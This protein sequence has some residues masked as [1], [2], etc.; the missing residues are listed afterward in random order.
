MAQQVFLDKEKLICSICFD[1]QKDPVTIPCGHSYCL[2]CIQNF[3]IGEEPKAPSCPQCRQNFTS[4]PVLVRNTILAE[5]VEDARKAE[6]QPTSSERS[7]TGPEH[8]DCDFCEGK[9]LKAAMSCLTCMVSYCEQHL[10]LHF[11]VAALKKH[12][13]VKATLKL[14]ENICIRHDEVIKIFC[15]TDQ[16]CICSL[17]SMDEHKGHDMVSAAAERAERQTKLGLDQQKVQQRILNLEEDLEVLQQAVEAI[18]LSAEKTIKESQNL[19]KGL[20]CLLEQ[21]CSEVEQKVTSYQRE[22]VRKVEELQEKMQHEITKLKKTEAELDQLSST[23]DHLH[24]LNNYSSLSDLSICTDLP[25]FEQA[26]HC[27]D[28]A[29]KAVSETREKLEETLRDQTTKILD[30]V[31]VFLP[32]DFRSREDFMKYYHQ[33]TLDPNTANRNLSLSEQNRTATWTKLEQNYSSHPDRFAKRSQVLSAEGLT[34]RCY[35]EVDWSGVVYIAVA[36]KDRSGTGTWDESA[37]GFNDKSWALKCSPT[38]Y[39][40]Y[41]K[42]SCVSIAAPRSSRVGVYLNHKAGTLSFY[43]ISDSMT[44]LHKVQTTFTQPLHAGF[45]ISKSG[46]M[47]RLLK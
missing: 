5:L 6:L 15:R 17:C 30:I 35:W 9:K 20:I 38:E 28:D 25:S 32:E 44:L 10:Q 29:L 34:G 36:Y 31:D 1:L 46:G 12:K 37:F 13:L 26:Q 16:K 4:R 2:E 33:I 43:S 27:F 18:N 39:T 42:S 23:E 41:H 24:F 19:F 22:E 40:F 47:I 14:Q 11:S 8:V 21:K 7:G 45:W 3:W